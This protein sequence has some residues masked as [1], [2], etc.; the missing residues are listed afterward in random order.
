MQWLLEA[1]LHL[2]PKKCQFHKETVRHLRLIISIKGISID[3][4]KVETGRNWSQER[5]TKNE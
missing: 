2:K 3:E 1:G 4:D 5:K